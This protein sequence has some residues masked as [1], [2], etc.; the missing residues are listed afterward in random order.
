MRCLDFG[1]PEP[2][3]N[4]HIKINSENEKKDVMS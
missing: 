4:L 3:E 1:L 2:D